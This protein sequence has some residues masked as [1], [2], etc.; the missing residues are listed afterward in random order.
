[1]NNGHSIILSS[2][3]LIL[4]GCTENCKKKYLTY[5]ENS[6][7]IK[8]DGKLGYDEWNDT[9]QEKSFTFPWQGRTP[10]ATEFY[11]KVDAKYF[12]FA[13]GV[14]D[15]NIIMV[16][17]NNESDV[18]KGDRV[19]IFFAKS[20]DLKEYYCL[21]IGPSGRVLDYKASFYRVFDDSWDFPNL[22]T[23][24]NIHQVGYTVEGKIPIEVL[25]AL[26]VYNLGKAKSCFLI[27]LYRAEFSHNTTSKEPKAE[28]ISWVRPDTKDPDFH[29]SSSFGCFCAKF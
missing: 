13:Y 2:I 6:S 28:W 21:E 22:M 11:A 7:K 3:F 25:K 9:K 29:V 4:I 26:G 10:P 23:E 14:E 1:M 8:V 5:A 18:A 16:D 12:Y 24:A 19:E 15:P 20:L 17:S 27:G